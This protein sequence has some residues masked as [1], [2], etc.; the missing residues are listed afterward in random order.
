MIGFC[1]AVGGPTSHTA[2]IARALGIP[3]IVGAGP[4]VL[5]PADGAVAVLDGEI[6]RRC[7]DACTQVAVL[8]IHAMLARAGFDQSQRRV[9]RESDLT[10]AGHRDVQGLLR[11]RF[12]HAARCNNARHAT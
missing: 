12:K 2:I 5:A 9:R 1:T 6:A 3:A 10:D 7:P 4:A 11:I 8:Q